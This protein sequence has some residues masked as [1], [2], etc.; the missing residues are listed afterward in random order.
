MCFSYEYYI[1]YNMLNVND[2]GYIKTILLDHYLSSPLHRI[3][4]DLQRV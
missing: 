3:P 1:R 4:K 2:S